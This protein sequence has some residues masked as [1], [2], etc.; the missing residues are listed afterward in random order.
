MKFNGTKE[1]L[2]IMHTYQ[3]EKE[4]I[5]KLLKQGKTFEQGLK[6]MLF[7]RNKDI[8]KH[9]MDEDEAEKY[10]TQERPNIFSNK[11]KINIR[12]NV[13]NNKTRKNF[14]TLFELNED[15]EFDDQEKNNEISYFD[16]NQNEGVL[17][18]KIKK[19]ILAKQNME[20]TQSF[21]PH[22]FN[23][24]NN[25]TENEKEFETK[26]K[27]NSRRSTSLQ[28][29]LTN[30]LYTTNKNLNKNNNL[31][32]ISSFNSTNNTLNFPKIN[33]PYKT[34]DSKFISNFNDE[35]YEMNI[36]RMKESLTSH[37]IMKH[38][39]NNSKKQYISNIENIV[40]NPE[41]VKMV[42]TI[43]KIKFFI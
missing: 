34:N 17:M 1:F 6:D 33:Q 20:K 27:K 21:V 39:G 25:F 35:N 12:T 15:E 38:L 5:N 3:S 22:S 14:I 7:Q 10:T 19:K 30:N 2:N 8:K 29:N 31:S 28:F 40:R 24:K 9:E 41:A 18:N 43:V 16:N 23:D 37:S 42:G 13:E 36:N 11:N 26:N 32:Q 4:A